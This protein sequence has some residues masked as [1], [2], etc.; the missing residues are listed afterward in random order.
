[1]RMKN[2]IPVIS[3]CLLGVGAANAVEFQGDAA[4]KLYR[5]LTLTGVTSV[6]LMQSASVS[7][8]SVVCGVSNSNS[9]FDGC[10][11]TD[12]NTSRRI[13]ISNQSDVVP[14]YVYNPLNSA[15]V[16]MGSNFPREMLP[17]SGYLNFGLFLSNLSCV[18]SF[19]YSKSKLVY[20]CSGY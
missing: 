11:F 3:A 18:N 7:V 10:A 15:G 1:M 5:T 13:F 12:R 6:A 9:A 16:Q 19:D 4:E 17:Y 2:A 14:Y 8:S 20:S